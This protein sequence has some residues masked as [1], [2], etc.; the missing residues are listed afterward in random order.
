MEKR[1][2]AETY[3][4][5]SGYW[6]HVSKRKLVQQAIKKAVDGKKDIHILDAGCGTGI[7]MSELQE[8]FSNVYGL[9]KSPLALDYCRKRGLTNVHHGNLEKVLPFRDKS[10]DAIICLDVI[11]HLKDDRLAI[12]EFKRILKPKG[13]IFITVPAYMFLWTKHDDILWH[14]RRYRRRQLDSLISSV[15]FKIKKSSYFYSFLIPPAI[16]LFK[17]KVMFNSGK[18]KTSVVPPKPINWLLLQICA[19]ERL[20]INNVSL[21][22]GISILAV[23]QKI[24]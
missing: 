9:D 24:K 21:P 22:T 23:A 15:G 4:L 14:K 8:Y 18:S 13:F 20:I 2:Y 19:L 6:W 7:M 17:L 10:F 11:E 16:V 12:S 5:E 3:R 1:V